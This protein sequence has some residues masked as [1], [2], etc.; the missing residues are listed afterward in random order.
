LYLIV[1]YC[2]YHGRGVPSNIPLAVSYYEK[3]L[4]QDPTVFDKLKQLA[5]LHDGAAQFVIAEH[6]AKHFK[7]YTKA[8]KYYHMVTTRDR[9]APAQFRIGLCYL[10][11][12]G[13]PMDHEE[14]YSYICLASH[15]CKEAKNF[16]LNPQL[17]LLFANF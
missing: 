13:V 15:D 6:Y 14:G 2:Y 3:A 8:L 10:L 11:G 9:Y 4:L 12:K 7:D 1:G 17:E 16:L 5:D